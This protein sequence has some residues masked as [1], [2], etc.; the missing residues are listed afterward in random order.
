M[1]KHR[2][3]LEG[4][5]EAETRHLVRR[6]PCY[7]RSHEGDRPARRLE[8]L[9][10]QIEDRSLAGAVRADQRMN[11]GMMHVEI[12]VF[13]GCECTEGLGETTRRKNDA[14]FGLPGGG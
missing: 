6:R 5:D 8:K 3:Y 11:A 2:R 12:D 10:Q 9:G 14:R 13:H 4:S 1:R 7:V